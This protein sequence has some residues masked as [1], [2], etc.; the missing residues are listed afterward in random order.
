M[1]FFLSALRRSFTDPASL[2]REAPFLATAVQFFVTASALIVF[3]FLV[4][5]IIAAPRQ[6]ERV[7]TSASLLVPEFKAELKNGILSIS[8][9]PQPYEVRQDDFFLLVNTVTTS[10]ISAAG[11]VEKNKATAGIVIT[12][13]QM[14]LVN[15]STGQDEIRRWKEIEDFSVSKADLLKVASRLSDSLALKVVVAVLA[16]LVG[17]AGF[18]IVKSLNL[19]IVAALAFLILRIAQRPA[20]FKELYGLGLLTIAVPVVVSALFSL[21]PL[22]IP[23]VFSIAWLAWILAISFTK[24][25]EQTVSSNQTGGVV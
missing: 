16:L 4:P 10:S 5:I 9:L 20:S 1:R 8:G 22:V 23:G 15:L 14:E 3:L 18:L 24:S 21:L 7:S 19:V 25:T 13:E 6:L 11:A 17:Y 2:K 12:R